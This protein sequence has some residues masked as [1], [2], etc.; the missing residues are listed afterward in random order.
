MEMRA[1]ES[2]NIGVDL[3][4]PIPPLAAALYDGYL[5]S[6]CSSCFSPFPNPHSSS[7]H[8][9][10]CSPRC[11]H[12]SLSSEL[13]L[14]QSHSPPLTSAD[15]RTAVCLLHSLPHDL[16]TSHPDRLAGLLTNRDKFLSRIDDDNDEL[17]YSRIH[18]GAKLMALSRKK[19]VDGG[20]LLLLEEA[21]LCIVLS[22]AVEVEDDNGRNLGIAIYDWRFC[23]IN[24]S[25]SPNACYRFSFSSSLHNEEPSSPLLIA[26]CPADIETWKLAQGIHAYGPKII[27]RSISRITKGEEI[28]ITYTDL[29]QPKLM[30]QSELLSKYQF[31]CC[32][33]RCSSSPPAYVDHVL[34]EISAITL[35]MKSLDFSHKFNND[36]VAKLL[37]NYIDEAIT[38]YLSDGDP[39]S[40]CDKLENMIAQGLPSDLLPTLEGTPQLTFR[41]HPFH[42][43]SLNAYTTLSS[44]YKIRASD[45]KATYTKEHY[46]AS[47]A[48]SLLLAG[49]TNFLFCSESSLI[50]SLANFW[51]SAGESLLTLARSSEWIPPANGESLT[52]SLGSLKAQ[53]CC[54]CSLIR[55][56]ESIFSS[57]QTENADFETISRE[58]HN[59]VMKISRK[60]WIFLTQGRDDLKLFK[61]PIDF[62]WLGKSCNLQ[63]VLVHQV[64]CETEVEMTNVFQLGVHCLLYGGFLATICYGQNSNLSRSIQNVMHTQERCIFGLGH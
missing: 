33:T 45:F 14:L 49:A 25:C 8:L 9:S 3:T 50:V 16:A 37:A 17:T 32:C 26:L 55:R 30:R 23:W 24:H 52:S 46:R 2:V 15:L 1:K 10:F 35:D 7:H 28:T 56:C 47:A 53:N 18:E 22:N 36:D 21:A 6:H 42:H 19:V 51:A 31:A 61:D 11:S 60:V 13:H 57:S 62:S 43:L 63:D 64:L 20:S 4:P 12:L 58:F 40:C 59:C 39:E 5:H 41:L 48:Y 44:A 38:E 29:L 34:Q 27:V 54:S